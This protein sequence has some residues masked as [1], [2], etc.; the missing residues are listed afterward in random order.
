MLEPAFA[1]YLKGFIDPVGAPGDMGKVCLARNLP[2]APDPDG[3]AAAR[4]LQDAIVVN[5]LESKLA[6]NQSKMR[7]VGLANNT[8]AHSMSI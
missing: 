7:K 1:D 4:V 8:S 2:N 6:C 3:A 5:G